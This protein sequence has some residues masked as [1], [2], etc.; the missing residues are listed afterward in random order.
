LDATRF[1]CTRLA[2]SCF[3]GEWDDQCRPV[4][5]DRLA[6]PHR[7]VDRAHAALAL[8]KTMAAVSPNRYQRLCDQVEYDE[9]AGRDRQW[10]RTVSDRR[11]RLAATRA[12][13]LLRSGGWCENPACT[14]IGYRLDV[15]E[16]GGPL[17]EVHHTDGDPDA[18]HALGGRDHP[19]AALALCRNCHGLVTYG[20]NRAELTVCRART[21][22]RALTW[23]F[24]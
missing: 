6:E 9:R 17:L 4:L 10:T 7:A 16:T 24:I 3:A 18:A 11:N 1:E 13:V 2:W 19:T 20:R 21:H 5:A 23:A 8:L 22:R 14:D 15:T 12:A